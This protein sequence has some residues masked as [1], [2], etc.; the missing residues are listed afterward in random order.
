M[1]DNF[2]DENKIYIVTDYV[3]GGELFE[4]LKIK[5]RLDESTVAKYILQLSEAV[6]YLHELNII[7][8]D[9]KPENILLTVNDDIVLCDFGWSV[10]SVDPQ[11]SVCGT[12]D[13]MCPEMVDSEPHDHR[14]D[15][16]DIGV[17]TY[18]LLVGIPPFM[19]KTYAATY[20]KI[21]QADVTYPDYLSEEA[22]D[23]MKCLL[24]RKPEDRME[25]SEIKNHPWI[26]SHN[27][28]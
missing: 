9:I 23:L 18:E 11:T 17:L 15:L 28:S 1:I 7:H 3:E 26:V 21:S 24:V 5:S 20:R 16:W 8:R 2:E 13:Y 10:R 14:L 25:A 22:I 12:L 4:Y 6:D 27:Q 19:S